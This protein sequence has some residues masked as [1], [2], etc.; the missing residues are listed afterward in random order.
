MDHEEHTEICVQVCYGV[1]EA[2]GG[3]EVLE[4]EFDETVIDTAICV[5]EVEPAHRD[6]LV[7]LKG[8]CDGS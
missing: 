4:C 6:G 1:P 3:M 8:F 7:L 5:G 2:R